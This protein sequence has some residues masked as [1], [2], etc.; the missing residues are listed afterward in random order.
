MTLVDQPGAAA[1]AIPHKPDV[2]LIVAVTVGK[3]AACLVNTGITVMSVAE[4]GG[5]GF[6]DLA[7]PEEMHFNVPHEGVP[8][9]VDFLRLDFSPDGS[10]IMEVHSTPS[11]EEIDSS[12]ANNPDRDPAEIESEFLSNT[13]I[14]PDDYIHQTWERPEDSVH[15]IR[16]E[17]GRI[18]E[19]A[20]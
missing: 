9:R 19:L 12:I 8:M 5:T 6:I 4:R 2:Y 16:A 17:I 3:L 13:R 18:H 20:I 1:A 7:L 15:A 14:F 10:A 11:R